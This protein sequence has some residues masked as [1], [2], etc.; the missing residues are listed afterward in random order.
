M[1]AACMHAC[2][3]VDVCYGLFVCLFAS[4]SGKTLSFL[5]PAL[6]LLYQVKFLPRNGTGVLVISP[7]RE[8]SLQI[9]DVAV[10]L[11]KFLPQ[12]L[13]LVM[14]GANRRNEA[15][16]LCKGVNV[17]V[18]TPGRLLDHMQ[19]TKVSLSET[20]QTDSAE[21]QL[22]SCCCMHAH[23]SVRVLYT[24]TCC[25][26]SLMKPTG[27]WRLASRKS[28]MPSSRCCPRPDKPV[29]SQQHKPPRSLT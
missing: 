21:R 19:N 29:F 3:I 16:K 22:A 4:G 27:F 9:Y 15:E 23:A 7:T 26:W 25:R 18:A 10:E 20:A 11:A 8:L 24:K 17:L 13:G 2:V 12:T 1:H 14:G 6:E 28:S 5:V